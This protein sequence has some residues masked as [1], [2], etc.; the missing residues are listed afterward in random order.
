ML[1]FNKCLYH[2]IYQGLAQGCIIAKDRLF[3][4][5][6][7]CLFPIGLL[8]GGLAC[9]SLVDLTL[10]CFLT[11]FSVFVLAASIC[12]R[13]WGW[14]VISCIFIFVYYEYFS[15]DSSALWS[16][17]LVS[18]FVLSWGICTLGISLISEERTKK[19]HQYDRLSEEYAEVQASYDQAVRDKAIACEFLEKR[20]QSLESDL[21]KYRALLQESCKKQENMALDFQILADQKNSW[22]EDYAL[23]HNEYVRLVAGDET[24]S[25]FSWVSRKDMSSTIQKQ[26]EATHSWIHILQEK[27]AKLAS[28]EGDLQ[29]ERSLR[30]N[31]ENECLSLHSR[32]QENKD[33][34]LR[35]DA[36]QS[37]L[38]KKDGELEKLQEKLHEYLSSEKALLDAQD[39]S[40]KTKYLQ[41]KE[42]F[43]AKAEALV[44]ARKELFLVREN[45]LTLQRQE[46]NSL[47]F[48]DMSD[49]EIIEKLLEYVE[50]LEEEITS[51]EELV[52]HTL[53]R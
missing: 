42:Q 50:N 8:F 25:V 29:K 19:K 32:V 3:S 26:G 27:D 36:L 4:P 9:A 5:E 40:Y 45:Y 1:V 35:F 44:E 47:S 21:E 49:I 43:S 11:L 48:I 20:T 31:L 13:L 15:I 39:K 37:L 16:L 46:E 2:K 17:G 18:S 34:Q 30:E 51:L 23:L 38:E 53:S 7:V 12:G 24:T 28:L 22:L 10:V 6:S 41:L 33:L 14:G 52:S